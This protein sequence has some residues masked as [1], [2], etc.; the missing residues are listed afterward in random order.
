VHGVREAGEE[1]GDISPVV[2]QFGRSV[3][4]YICSCVDCLIPGN[5][6]FAMCVNDPH[7]FSGSDDNL[8]VA[9]AFSSSSIVVDGIL[10]GEDMVEINCSPC[11]KVG[12]FRIWELRELCGIEERCFGEL[13]VAGKILEDCV[14]WSNGERAGGSTVSWMTHAKVLGSI[15]RLVDLSSD[16]I[17]CD[18]CHLVDPAMFILCCLH[19]HSAPLN[20]QCDWSSL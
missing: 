13:R 12:P 6:P 9:N 11:D 10:T 20:P 16:P 1:L 3:W 18:L 5:D 14:C 2:P 19:Y 4:E 8:A 7:R 15:F 17:D